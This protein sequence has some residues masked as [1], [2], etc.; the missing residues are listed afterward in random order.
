MGR[1][2]KGDI[3]V[4]LWTEKDSPLHKGVY[5]GKGSVLYPYNGVHRT[6][7]E[8]DRLE[9]DT[10]H[11]VKVGHCPV[12]ELFREMLELYTDNKEI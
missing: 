8:P 6:T 11:F 10:E 4:N 2:K 5:M 7:F 1:F 9:N 3:M 12:E